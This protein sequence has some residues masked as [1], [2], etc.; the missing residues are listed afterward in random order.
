MPGRIRADM[1]QLIE[2]VRLNEHDHIYTYGSLKEEQVGCAVVMP[3]SALKYRF[4][5]Q[6]TIFNILKAMDQ[7][8]KTNCSRIMMIDSLSILT[9]LEKVLPSKNSMKN[10]FLNMLAEKGEIFKF[11]WVPAHTGI[12]GNEATDEAAKNALNEDILPRTKAKEMDWKRWLK[13]AANFRK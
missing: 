6:T 9:V 11:M 1:H 13:N 12:E 2:D 8:N 7:H 10:K 4:L 3:S 5:P